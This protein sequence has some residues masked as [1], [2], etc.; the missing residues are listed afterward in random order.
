M[1]DWP[2]GTIFG[3]CEEW[4]PI[5]GRC[6]ECGQWPMVVHSLDGIMGHVLNVHCRRR[7]EAGNEGCGRRLGVVACTEGLERLLWLWQTG[8]T[9]ERWP[10]VQHE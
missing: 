3:R 8:E 1:R 2:P 4:E 5:F 6:V 10:E 9:W 7:D